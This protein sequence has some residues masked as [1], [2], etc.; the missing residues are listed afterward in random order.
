VLDRVL[1][2]D[3]APYCRRFLTAFLSRLSAT[4]VL[5]P[6]LHLAA[7]RRLGSAHVRAG[8]DVAVLFD[9]AAEMAAEA[10]PV[11]AVGG[12]ALVAFP[13]IL[14]VVGVDQRRP[15]SSPGL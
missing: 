12:E 8:L 4:H 1:A 15:A 14:Q 7:H 6:G 9:V 3:R 11:A 5:R 13:E 10:D 2:F